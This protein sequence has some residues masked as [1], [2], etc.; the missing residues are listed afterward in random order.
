MKKA[1]FS[2]LLLLA[3]SAGRAQVVEHVTAWEGEIAFGPTFGAREIGADNK[4]GWSGLLELRRNLN[5]QPIDIGLQFRSSS[6][7]R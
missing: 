1:L 3:V 4:G 7:S 6:V 2:L 5:R